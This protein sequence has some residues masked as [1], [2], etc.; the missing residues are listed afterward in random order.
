[1]DASFLLWASPPC[2]LAV[3]ELPA[4]SEG[5]CAVRDEGD[6][7]QGGANIFPWTG[8]DRCLFGNRGC[9]V[10]KRGASATWAGK[11]ER[12]VGI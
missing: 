5:R 9:E 10:P 3:V 1:M 11:S 8:Q 2:H 12:D 4:T 7:A 6:Q